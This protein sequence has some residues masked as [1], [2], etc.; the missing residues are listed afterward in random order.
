MEAAYFLKPI[1]E[2]YGHKTRKR[3]YTITPPFPFGVIHYI[4]DMPYN[5]SAALL[6]DP[7]GN[8]GIEASY[9]CA[10]AI[11]REVLKD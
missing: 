11:L 6:S 4:S 2:M 3:H 8:N 7:M 1:S 9:G 5:L 10:R